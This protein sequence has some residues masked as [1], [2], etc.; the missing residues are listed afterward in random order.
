MTVIRLLL[1]LAF[2]SAGGIH[3]ISSV[4]DPHDGKFTCAPCIFIFDAC[5]C[6]IW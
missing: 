6:Y 5:Y 1:F 2:F 3:L 4:T